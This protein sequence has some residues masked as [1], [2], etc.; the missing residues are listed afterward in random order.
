VVVVCVV[1]AGSVV[2]VCSVVVVL[3]C[4]KANGVTSAHVPRAP[5][6]PGRRRPARPP[7][8]RLDPDRVGGPEGPT[9]GVRAPSVDKM[10]DKAFRV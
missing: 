3:V 9:G 4:A 2:V 7:G 5:G 6:C 1:V 8:G 10:V